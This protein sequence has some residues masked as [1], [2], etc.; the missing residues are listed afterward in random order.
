MMKETK[1]QTLFAPFPKEKCYDSTLHL[2][3]EGYLFIPNRVRKYNSKLFQTRLLGQKVSCMSGN[4][5]TELFYNPDYFTRKGVMPSRIQ[6]TLFGKKA[7][8]TLDGASH[9]HRKLLFTSIMTPT[10]IEK[11]KDLAWK[12]WNKNSTRFEKMKHVI[13]MDEATL[14][15]FQVACKWAGVP[16]DKSEARQK[17]KDMCAMIDAFGAVGPRHWIGR[18]ARN[19]S[20]V[21][22]DQ[23]IQ[24]VRAG[25]IIAP[26]DSALALIAWHR[27]LDG[28]LLDSHTAAIELLNILRPITA[29]AT[30]VTFGALALH[31]YPVQKEI[32]SNDREEDLTMFAQ[33]V[34]RY[35]PFA[36]FLAA[37]V[38]TDFEWYHY[39]FEKDR[40]VFLDLYGT[41]HD[42]GFWKYPNLFQ[43][44]NFQNQPLTPFDF[45]PQGG[46]DAKLGTRCPGD[47]LTLELL[48][49][50]IRFLVTKLEYQ[51][52]LQDLTYRLNRIPTFPKSRFLI[53]KVRKK[54]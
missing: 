29:I 5:A 52:P 13:L 28:K 32:L 2:L 4:E 6:E 47:Q 49:V 41:N 33:E 53:N 23:I 7:I 11:I 46:G 26:K 21:W 22:A 17:A 24:K 20:E 51:V 3:I 1:N 35:Y 34:R 42:S 43:P 10:Q 38:R 45:I 27:E 8:Q 48:K 19:R 31:Q 54:S 25:R 30:Y 39:H 44:E 18:C 15:F 50:S 16:L 36:P 9:V 37:R 12:Q 40:L 14:L